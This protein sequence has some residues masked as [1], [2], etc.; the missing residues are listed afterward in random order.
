MEQKSLKTKVFIKEKIYNES[1]E[2]PID[3]DFTMPDYYPDITKILKCRAVPR[4]SA[5]GVNAL[6]YRL[7][8]V[9]SIWM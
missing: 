7:K 6:V 8:K 1:A 4:I 3:V 5:K 9:K 2:L